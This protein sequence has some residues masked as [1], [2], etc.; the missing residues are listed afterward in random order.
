M[1]LVSNFQDIFYYSVLITGKR[2]MQNSAVILTRMSS[3]DMCF[4]DFFLIILLSTFITIIHYL[5]GI[6]AVW[7][8]NFLEV[9]AE[10]ASLTARLVVR[11]VNFVEA[12]VEVIFLTVCLVVW[13]VNFLE[14]FVEGIFC[15]V[16]RRVFS[17]EVLVEATFLTVHLITFTTFVGLKTYKQVFNITKTCP[18]NIQRF[19]KL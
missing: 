6:H 10:R 1:L 18:C 11:R 3:L 15:P 8:V 12:F 16:V 7:R 19:L 17:L 9:L 5:V 2:S 4:Q 14:A 13:R